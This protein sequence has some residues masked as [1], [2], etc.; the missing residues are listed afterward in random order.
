MKKRN[1]AVYLRLSSSYGNKSE[2]NSIGNQ[3]SIIKKYSKNNNLNVNVNYY[4]DDGYSGT[5]FERPDF[6]K[7]LKILKI[8]K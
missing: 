4:T 6:K 3:R 2:S 7:C 5:T 8:I 1:V